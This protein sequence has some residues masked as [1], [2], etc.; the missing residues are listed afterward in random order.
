M[1]ITATETSTTTLFRGARAL[2]AERRELDDAIKV[3]TARKAEIDAKVR[4]ALDEA[5]STVGVIA[6][7]PVVRL[8][9]RTRRDIDVQSLR[10]HEPAVAERFTRVAEFT[11]L[12]YA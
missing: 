10:E 5:G 1:T 3:L 6:G 2:I 4:G 7:M 9:P 12:H 11:I 8:T